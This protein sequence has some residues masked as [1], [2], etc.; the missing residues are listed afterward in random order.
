MLQLFHRPQWKTVKGRSHTYTKRVA[1]ILGDKNVR[2][3]TPI[4]SMKKIG[5]GVYDD[6]TEQRKQYELFTS[7]SDNSSDAVSVGVYDDII[8][9]CHT[10]T[11]ASI[12]QN[13]ITIDTTSDLNA[14]DSVTDNPTCNS[15]RKIDPTLIDTLSKIEFA[16]NVVYLHSDPKL[17]PQR[18]RAWAS[19]NCIGNS[20]RIQDAIGGG[21]KVGNANNNN[22]NTNTNKGAFEGAESGFGNTA[23][24]SSSSSNK[25]DGDKNDAPDDD[26]TLLE[27]K[28]GRMKAVYVTYWLNKL[29][30]E[31]CSARVTDD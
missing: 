4:V 29:Q 21:G 26:D 2:L 10:D 9:A 20:Q 28:E 27:G 14:A 15:H 13:N 23:T 8:F 16:N 1:E 18:K 7:S 3:S 24:S 25:L 31:F 5:W 12:L 6:G 17:M 30:T 19:W 11:A 22:N